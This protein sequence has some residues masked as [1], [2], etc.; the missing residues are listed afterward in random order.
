MSYSHLENCDA[1]FAGVS[2]SSTW[3]LFDWNA[4]ISKL[5]DEPKVGGGWMLQR[6]KTESANIYK[7][8]SRA[9]RNKN[10][11]NYVVILHKI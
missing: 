4:S 7:H 3:Y 10:T 11:T 2:L 6:E 8:T 1:K 5:G 9:I